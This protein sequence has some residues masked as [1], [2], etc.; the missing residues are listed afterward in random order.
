MATSLPS[1][2]SIV[3]AQF[4]H[5]RSLYPIIVKRV[6]EGKIKDSKKLSQALEDDAWR[7]EG[8]VKV[9]EGRR[10]SKDGEAGGWI[11]KA[12]LERLVRWKM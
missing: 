1:P 2:T 6:Y 12:E 7:Y 10:K 8:L 5:L 3:H 9:L 4:A 11:E